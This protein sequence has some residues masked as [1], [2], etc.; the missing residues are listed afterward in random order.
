MAGLEFEDDLEVQLDQSALEFAEIE[1]AMA[2]AL[3]KF[4]S[5]PAST[6]GGTKPAVDRAVATQA[7]QAD[8]DRLEREVSK[9]DPVVTQLEDQLSRVSDRFEFDDIRRSITIELE[10]VREAK[11][12]R[13]GRLEMLRADRRYSG[14]S[15]DALAPRIEELGIETERLKSE[16][17]EMTRVGRGQRAQQLFEDRMMLAVERGRLEEEVGRRGSLRLANDHLADIAL[18]R[19][20]ASFAA[21]DAAKIAALKKERAPKWKIDE[22]KSLADKP[23]ELRFGF[24]K[25]LDEQKAAA[26]AE[27]EKNLGKRIADN[28][29]QR[30]REEFRK[31]GF[32]TE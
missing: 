8:I 13:V 23:V 31:R 17:D 20:R 7:L 9:L 24:R 32:E 26:A 28:S 19:T 2:S 25:R 27:F 12:E 21:D 10:K 15:D 16:E 14:L 22:T 4:P 30:A 18:K 11:V 6:P 1:A 5:V 3:R 29:E